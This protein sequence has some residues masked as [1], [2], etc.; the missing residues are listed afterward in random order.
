[1]KNIH[2]SCTTF[3]HFSLDEWPLVVGSYGHIYQYFSPNWTLKR[4]WD[5]CVSLSWS[6]RNFGR[7][8]MESKSF[9]A[10]FGAGCR[11]NS[12]NSLPCGK[13]F[14]LLYCRR[15]LDSS[16]SDGTSLLRFC[17]AQ[18]AKDWYFVQRGKMKTD[19]T[20]SLHN[21][22]FGTEKKSH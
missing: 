4:V 3:D 17:A 14:S 1:M 16:A 7:N 15:Q 18:W 12:E 2:F 8:S 5:N 6:C 13:R 11:A 22:I 21:A 19:Y 9:L 10:V 20:G